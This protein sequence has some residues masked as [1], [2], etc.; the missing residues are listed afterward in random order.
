MARFPYE[1][2]HNARIAKMQRK[3]GL[4]LSMGTAAKL[5][6]YGIS[7][8]ESLAK[9]D[10][11]I[12][13][14]WPGVGIKTIDSIRRAQAKIIEQGYTPDEPKITEPTESSRTPMRRQIVTLSADAK[15]LLR[16]LGYSN[17]F[18]LDNLTWRELRNAK[19]AYHSPTFRE[20][21]IHRDRKFTPLNGPKFEP[22][23]EEAIIRIIGIGA[24]KRVYSILSELRIESLCQFLNTPAV[25]FLDTPSCGPKIYD[26]IFQ[27]QLYLREFLSRRPYPSST[28]IK[29]L[30][31]LFHNRT[32]FVDI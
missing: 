10:L 27:L 22:Y 25:K 12:A 32:K 2:S 18:D 26:E 16:S 30:I 1:N 17:F 13:K 21:L 4:E 19:N 8:P 23:Q 24:K 7:T 3:Y 20:I 6:R 9:L 11:A 28:Q 31:A 15:E 5:V 14:D 29:D